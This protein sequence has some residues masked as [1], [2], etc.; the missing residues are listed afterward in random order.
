MFKRLFQI[1]Y[2]LM[3]RTSVT[4]GELANRLE[5][6]ERTIYRDIEKLSEAGIPIYTNRGSGGGIS[7]L[8]DYVLDRTVLTPA[9]KLK[10]LESLQAFAAIGFDYEGSIDT[11]TVG[12]LKNFFGD[13]INDWIEID[14]SDWT[15]RDYEAEVFELL[16]GAILHRNYVTIS[17]SGTAKKTASRRIKP[18]KLCFKSQAWY[19]YAYCELRKDYR[20][21]KLHRISD[22]TVEETTFEFEPV[23]RLFDQAHTTSSNQ[24]QEQ[25]DAVSVVIEID[26]DWA[27]RAYDELSN[28]S[29]AKDGKLLCTL[30]ITD[31]EWF[32]GYILTYGNGARVIQ[33]ESVR[34]LI[35]NRLQLIQG[36]YK[37][38]CKGECK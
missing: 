28:L 17:Y 3:E 23:G 37:V 34:E 22:L 6:S 19:L 38:E 18:L 7:L 14:F 29:E 25:P 8:K 30:N 5:V 10:I 16:K 32:L 11:T 4:A 36:E 12:N 20:F 24:S 2:I 33:P 13:T 21:F 1:V 35:R 9:E 15:N 27:Y 31:M 26:S